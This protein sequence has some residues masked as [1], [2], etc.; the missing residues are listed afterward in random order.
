MS[1]L[2]LLNNGSQLTAYDGRTP[3]SYDG[4]SQFQKGLEVSQL[5]LNGRR[6]ISFDGA[7]Q[8]ERGLAV[9]QL[10]LDGRTPNRYL[11]NPPR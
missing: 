11:D 3:A 7:T 10:D 9:S 1:V 2:D 8:Y 5:D 6:P 4:A